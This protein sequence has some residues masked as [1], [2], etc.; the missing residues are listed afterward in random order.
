MPAVRPPPREEQLWQ[1]WRDTSRG[2]LAVLPLSQLRQSSELG[3]SL[4]PDCG[5]VCAA[6]LSRELP[7]SRTANDWRK[8]HAHLDRL[9][10]VK[11]EVCVP[12]SKDEFL[13]FFF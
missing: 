11:R 3:K 12:Q 9:G 4:C 10:I 5:E 13:K 6:F 2:A 7:N 8:R 1:L